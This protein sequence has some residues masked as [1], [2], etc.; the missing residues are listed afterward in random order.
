MA[1][2]ECWRFPHAKPITKNTKTLI[3]GIVN[4]TPDSFSGGGAALLTPQDAANRAL[5]LVAAGADVIDFG[6][7]STRPG[8]ATLTA[9]EELARLDDVVAL[10]R[11]RTDVPLSVDTYH[12]E[13]VAEVL[14]QGA[15]IVNDVSALRRGWDGDAGRLD[16][17]ETAELVRRHDAHVILMHMPAAP[18]DMQSAPHYRDVFR[19]VTD[20]LLARAAYAEQAGIPRER[21]WLDPG[22]GFG[23]TFHHNRELLLRLDEMAAVGYPLAAGLSRK[24]MIH[25]ALGLPVDERRAASLALAVTAAW[26]NA[27]MI[28]VHD[29]LD[30][31]RAVGMVDAL[32]Q[33]RTFAGT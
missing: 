21:I 15:D 13:T 23:K 3:M 30:T 20:F 10:V 7:E 29:V 4:L 16:N 14:R 25:D 1:N 26:K 17:G 11:A 32:R 9:A 5:D 28:R 6:A 33:G 12:T 31:A 18:G 8:A 19:E 27:A 24:R 22:F 2:H